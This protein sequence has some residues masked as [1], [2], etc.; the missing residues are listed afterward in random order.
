[1][2]VDIS[3]SGIGSAE[4]VKKVLDEDRVWLNSGA[5][6][7]VDGYVRFNIACPRNTLEEGLERLCDL[8]VKA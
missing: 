1:P 6:Y 5:M 2:W 4:L 7:G 3:A 8:L